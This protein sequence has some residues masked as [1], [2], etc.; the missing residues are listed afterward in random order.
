[1]K[2]GERLCIAHVDAERDF[3]GG[4]IQVFLLMEGLSEV[5]YRNVLFCPE[6]SL[7]ARQ[8]ERLGIECHAVRMRNSL[9][10]ASIF[11]LARGF[12]RCGADLVHLHTSRATW[13][14]GLAA[15]VARLPAL[16]TCRMERLFKRGWRTRLTFQS[17]VQH[18]VAISP[19]IAA[20][21]SAAG[22]PEARCRIIRSAVDPSMLAPC[23]ERERLRE[24]LGAD[25]DDR[26][27]LTLAALIRRK[28]LDILLDALALLA[29]EGRRPWLWIA[30]DGPLRG[31]LE[32]QAESLGL[33]EQVRFLG[34]RADVREL[35]AA[36]DLFVLPSRHEGLGVAALEAMAAGRAVVATAVGGLQEAVVDGRTGLLVPPGDAAALAG[37]IGRLLQ[38][39]V[40]R[41]HLAAAGPERVAEGYLPEQMV[42]A[43]EDLYRSVVERW[44]NRGRRA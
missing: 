19:A 42:L 43:Y 4:E 38:D 5:G 41:L 23:G 13:L 2:E 7:G 26:V 30:G 3:S 33:A 37:A 39:D 27:I 8:A 31:E 32:A 21:L 12:T 6:D 18:V 34:R 20:S 15:R 28:A 35:L 40:L 9:D 22:V 16:T 24:E 10:V 29:E 36:C 44:K 1:M 25:Y 17:L 14:G 11:A